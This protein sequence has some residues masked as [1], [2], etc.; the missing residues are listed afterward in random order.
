MSD[1]VE[2]PPVTING[3]TFPVSVTIRDESA[4]FRAE[5]GAATVG[6]DDY[7]KLIEQMKVA[8]RKSRV[9]VAVRFM[10]PD[11][12]ERGTATGF[13]ATTRRPLVRWDSGKTGQYEG[14]G[15]PLSPD[16]DPAELTRLI[17]AEIDARR[18]LERFRR[19]HRIDERHYTLAASVEAVITQAQN[20]LA[21][22]EAAADIP[23]DA[24]DLDEVSTHA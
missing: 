20:E 2:L 24:P 15:A 21:R 13:H 16:T 22:A 17:Q 14:R 11:T 3:R 18:A 4:W 23:A 1:T 19:E 6:A 9:K 10:D 12:G 7:R 5:V 8:E